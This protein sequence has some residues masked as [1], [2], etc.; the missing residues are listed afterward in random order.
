MYAKVVFH[1]LER[2]PFRLVFDVYVHYNFQKIMAHKGG[3]MTE[4]CQGFQIYPHNHKLICVLYFETRVHVFF[5]LEKVL[6]D[7]INDHY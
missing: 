3:Q 7:V 1:D 6:F 2:V 5:N 4:S